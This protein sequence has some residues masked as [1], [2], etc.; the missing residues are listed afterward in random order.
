MANLSEI[1]AQIAALSPEDLKKFREWFAEFEEDLWDKQ[2]EADVLAG[3]LDALGDHALKEHT[4]GRS[5]PLFGG[6][7]NPN[8]LA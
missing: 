2:I 6:S 5:T 4:E 3:K 7:S 8:N 1:E